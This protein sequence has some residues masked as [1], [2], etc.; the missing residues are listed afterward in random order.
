MTTQSK[1]S[2]V[3]QMRW[4][5]SLLVAIAIVAS[6]AASQQRTLTLEECVRIAWG[7]QPQVAIA[8]KSWRLAEERLKSI[9]AN[10]FPQISAGYQFRRS[11]GGDRLRD[12]RIFQF[13]R[14]ETRT[15]KDRS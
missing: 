11:R 9:R 6:L 3:E 2:E 1:L 15:R 14:S 12:F 4:A 8:E 10:L 13:Q 7:E 5:V